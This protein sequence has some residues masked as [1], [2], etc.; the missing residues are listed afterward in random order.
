M[1]M[2]LGSVFTRLHWLILLSCLAIGICIGLKFRFNNEDVSGIRAQVF[3]E[4][5]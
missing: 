5:I 3:G 1:L 4:I 2:Y